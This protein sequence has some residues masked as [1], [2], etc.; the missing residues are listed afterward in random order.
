M[1]FERHNMYAVVDNIITLYTS[2]SAR[3]EFYYSRL[4]KNTCY[5][6]FNAHYNYL[7][8]CDT[9]NRG[10]RT[11][12]AGATQFFFPCHSKRRPLVR[13]LIRA[14]PSCVCR[15]AYEV[16]LALGVWSTSRPRLFCVYADV[17]TPQIS[18]PPVYPSVMQMSVTIAF[19]WQARARPSRRGEKRTRMGIGG[20]KK[21]NGFYISARDNNTRIYIAGRIN[22]R[23]KYAYLE[24][25]VHRNEIINRRRR[26]FIS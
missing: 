18:L 7:A 11:R 17:A 10:H 15:R 25:V 22:V 13:A 14:H 20:G 2:F 1:F 24:I 12:A 21:S 26:K 8:R 5:A 19:L 4:K 9:D 23:Y 6:G 16:I 3:I